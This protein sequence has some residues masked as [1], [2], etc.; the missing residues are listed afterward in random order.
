M[1]NELISMLVGGLSG[2]L[3]GFW[4]HSIIS[5]ANDCYSEVALIINSR[6]YSV[7]SWLSLR[8]VLLSLLLIYLIIIQEFIANFLSLDYRAMLRPSGIAWM[9]TFIY[10]SYKKS[11][12]GY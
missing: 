9:F 7:V 8:I 12:V 10:V 6:I 5:L 3:I 4:S 1:I 11:K 2:V